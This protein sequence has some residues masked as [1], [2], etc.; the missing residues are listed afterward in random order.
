MEIP[1]DFPK[2]PPLSAL[3]GSHPKLAV[4]FQHGVYKAEGA[5]EHIA[6]RFDICDDLR[7]QLVEYSKRKLQERPE[8]TLDTYLGQ[9]RVS[10]PRKGWGLSPKEMDWLVA[11][12][13]LELQRPD[14]PNAPAQ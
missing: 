9:L 13:R 8:W 5:D 7:Q 2:E 10:L 14:G 11:R 6:Q 4:V 12:V 1:E 3:T